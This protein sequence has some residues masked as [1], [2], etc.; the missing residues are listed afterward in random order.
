MSVN[1][2]ANTQVINLSKVSELGG[3]L[4]QICSGKNQLNIKRK[5]ET[6][7][8]IFDEGIQ[9]LKSCGELYITEKSF[10]L[11]VEY[12]VFFDHN[13]FTKPDDIQTGQIVKDKNNFYQN[14]M[15]NINLINNDYELTLIE[16]AKIINVRKRMN[17]EI[18]PTNIYTDSLFSFI[19][20]I[21]KIENGYT[22]FFKE[23]QVTKMELVTTKSGHLEV[24]R[25][26]YRDKMDYGNGPVQV[27][28]QMRYLN[29][30]IEKKIDPA[31]FSIEKYVAIGKKG[32]IT[33][34]KQFENYYILNQIQ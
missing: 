16:N 27:V 29:F 6:E 7:K 9:A 25:Y 20:S 14:E 1:S 13:D 4:T 19:E 22:Y 26:Y 32:V 3:S 12:A 2:Y 5:K 31:F 24:I 33:P 8:S 10:S 18:V 34:K 21:E 17:K 28:T 15:G 30:K 23:G 11:D